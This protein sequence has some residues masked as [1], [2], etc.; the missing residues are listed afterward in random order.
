MGGGDPVA[1]CDFGY[2]RAFMDRLLWR[3]QVSVCKEIAVD[4]IGFS[5]VILVLLILLIVVAG[6]KLP[7]LGDALGRGVQRV[8]HSLG[9]VGDDVTDGVPTTKA[10]RS[11]EK[12]ETVPPEKSGR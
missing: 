2:R 4:S 10:T 8:R 6:T 12:S 7:Q 5:D 3:E 11:R 1:G 9:G